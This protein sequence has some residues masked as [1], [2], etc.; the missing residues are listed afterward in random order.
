V[1]KKYLCVYVCIYVCIYVCFNTHTHTQTQ[2]HSLTYIYRTL[3][4]V[5]DD[6]SHGYTRMLETYK[7]PQKNAACIHHTHSSTL[8]AK[9]SH[10]YTT[11]LKADTHAYIHANIHT[12]TPAPWML[13][14]TWL[15]NTVKKHWVNFYRSTMSGD[16]NIAV[17]VRRNYFIT[18]FR[19]QNSGANMRQ[20]SLLNMIMGE[21]MP[22]VL[23]SYTIQL[24]NVQQAQK[25]ARSM[26]SFLKSVV[27]QGKAKKQKIFHPAGMQVYA[28]MLCVCI[29]GQGVTQNHG[30]YVKSVAEQ[31]CCR[32]IAW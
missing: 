23:S 8:D 22:D 2:T 31:T 4:F 16:T 19:R 6:P 24:I 28:C 17:F 14:L 18:S 30:S 21:E 11:Q 29:A 13:P 10:G 7:H 20:N 32:A 5:S 9:S 12:Q 1:K 25:L 26:V 27:E 15:Y 3:S